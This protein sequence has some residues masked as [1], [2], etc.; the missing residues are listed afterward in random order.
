[1]AEG[2]NLGAIG[3]IILGLVFL[4]IA[5]GTAHFG[6]LE[7]K[8][9]HQEIFAAAAES[10]L[11]VFLVGVVVHTYL[12][13]ARLREEKTAVLRELSRIREKV[14]NASF[15]MTAHK[16]ARTWTEQT[17]ELVML[18]PRITDLH[19]AAVPIGSA[20]AS[21]KK[22]LESLKAEYLEKH[23][24]VATLGTEWDKI[25]DTVPS[26]RE[27]VMSNESPLLKA[28]DESIDLLNKE[29]RRWA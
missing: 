19:D 11:G 13:R 23:D 14:R 8:E 21:A 28:L 7:S 5:A 27:L 26:S 25:G 4:C 12:W 17:R 3:L 20:L 10:V 1:M 16:S 9:I 6:H 2:A 22:H 24:S 15:L 18:V 29:L